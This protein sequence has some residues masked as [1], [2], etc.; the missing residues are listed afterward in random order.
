MKH[1]TN[2][3]L[4]YFSI[5]RHGYKFW[6][7]PFQWLLQVQFLHLVVISQAGS[8]YS[9]LWVSS[10]IIR[11]T[12]SVWIQQGERKEVCVMKPL[13]KGNVTKEIISYSEGCPICC[14]LINLQFSPEKRVMSLYF[15]VHLGKACIP[16]HCVNIYLQR[17]EEREI[18]QPLKSPFSFTTF[19]LYGF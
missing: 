4:E 15:P 11:L 1:I 10:F 19:R 3:F 7:S 2:T 18:G 16:Y 17:W 14:L 9:F 12:S 13:G 5:Y 6:F 8:P